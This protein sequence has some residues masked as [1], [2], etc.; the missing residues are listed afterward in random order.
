MNGKA[1]KATILE[2]GNWQRYGR[3]HIL[4]MLILLRSQFS[5]SREYETSCLYYLQ[6]I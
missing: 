3:T 5:L 1:E 6:T 4:M 2:D